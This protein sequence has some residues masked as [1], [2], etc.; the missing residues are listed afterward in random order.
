MGVMCKQL[1]VTLVLSTRPIFFC[2]AKIPRGEILEN[3]FA[4]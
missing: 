4:K 1:H 3:G 2:L